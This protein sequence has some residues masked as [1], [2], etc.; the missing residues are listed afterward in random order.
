MLI[1]KFK[2]TQA[3]SNPTQ[4]M[5]ESNQRPTLES[6]MIACVREET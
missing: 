6:I 3:Q 2:E 4:S 1:S 5:D